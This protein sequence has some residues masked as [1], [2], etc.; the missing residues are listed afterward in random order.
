[1]A[2]TPWRLLPLVISGATPRQLGRRAVS[3]ATVA[4]FDSSNLES[5]SPGRAR[6]PD[7]PVIIAGDDDRHLVATHGH[8]PGREKA[9][10]AT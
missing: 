6:F 2:W 10:A 5:V 9:E 4:A 8:N 7:K 3:H 1:M